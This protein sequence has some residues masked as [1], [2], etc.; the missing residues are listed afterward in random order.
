M[1]ILA[2]SDYFENY[3][4]KASFRVRFQT[5][6]GMS[7]LGHQ[8]KFVYPDAGLVP[9]K[10]FVTDS[11]TVQAT[12]G[13]LPM[14][15]RVGGFGLIDMIAKSLI[16]LFGDYDVIHVT[17]GHRPSQFIPCLLGKYFKR[18][19][20]VDECWEWLGKGGYADNRKGAIG[21]I[22]AFY[23]ARCEIAFK[24]LFDRI[25]VI[26]TALKNRFDKTDLV[27]VLHG[28]AENSCLK[29]YGISEAR[30]KLGI[31]ENGFCIGM[32]NL[33]ASDHEENKIFFSAFGQLC[34]RYRDLFL[35]ATGSDETYISGIGQ[36]YH[37]T[38]RLISPGYVDFD[39][40]NAYLGSCNVFVLPITNTNIN[41]GRWPN[42]IGDY[43]CLG[44]PIITNPTGDIKGLF[45]KY[46]V[47]L[48]CEATPDAFYE[49]LDKVINKRLD[50]S[51]C[52][53]DCEYVATNVLS[54]DKRVND[55]LTIFERTIEAR[56]PRTP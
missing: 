27:T 26:A 50:I 21:R 31:E 3:Q 39:T 2:L 48:L 34:A 22:V 18:T 36:T 46:K 9:Q 7:K 52:T 29:R 30:Q 1:R 5:A 14:R 56:R 32:S 17:N 16:V 40:Y 55:L 43:V 44:R 23:D 11:F 42:K 15:L 13:L 53:D 6:F 10:K 19:L 8:V 41:R 37:F 25:V 12:P 47:G 49:L 54:F 38:D 35:V 4:N 20:I 28:G 51:R 33:V 45:E 24:R